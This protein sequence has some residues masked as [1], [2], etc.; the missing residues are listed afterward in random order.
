MQKVGTAQRDAI[1]ERKEFGLIKC[2]LR[3]LTIL[4]LPYVFQ[5]LLLHHLFRIAITFECSCK[6]GFIVGTYSLKSISYTYLLCSIVIISTNDMVYEC[7]VLIYMYRNN[8]IL[9]NCFT[10]NSFR[11]FYSIFF[12]RFPIFHI[13]I[14]VY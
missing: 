10:C 5:I 12:F 4:I 6:L 3:Y 7:D 9:I 13:Y 8:R 1:C 11:I 2:D 14:L